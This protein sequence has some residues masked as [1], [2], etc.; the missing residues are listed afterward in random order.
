MRGDTQVKDALLQKYLA[1]V[2][3]MIIDF[4]LVEISHIPR[5]QNTRVDV[6]SKVEST[7][8][9]RINHYFVQETLERPN[10][11]TNII[12]AVVEPVPRT[13]TTLIKEYI[14]EGK[15]QDDLT[16]AITI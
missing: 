7:R 14:E 13:W 2:K 3:K 16:E 8:S 10:Y 12:V 15:P 9:S 5:E 1:T 11:G 4:N 6:L